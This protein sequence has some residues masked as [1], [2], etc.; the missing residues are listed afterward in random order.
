M[1]TENEIVG[2][3]CRFCKSSNIKILDR[4]DGKDGFADIEFSCDSC[5][6]WGWVVIDIEKK[7]EDNANC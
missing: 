7:S 3:V 6:R 1:P 2:L 4:F 5:G